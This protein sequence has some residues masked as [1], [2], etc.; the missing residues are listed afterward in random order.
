MSQRLF[1]LL[2]ALLSLSPLEAQYI[3]VLNIGYTDN[4]TVEYKANG[5]QL[6]QH[7][8]WANL[9]APLQLNEQKDYLIPMLDYTA[10][11]LELDAYENDQLKFHDVDLG[12]GY[13][14]NWPQSPW[15]GYIGV[16]LAQTSDFTYF[17]FRELNYT[18][19]LLA[20][21]ELKKTLSFRLGFNFRREAFGHLFVP[22]VG[23]NWRI[24][25]QLRLS[26]LSFDHLKLEY[27]FAR[28]LGG[29]IR[30]QNA[31]YSFYL[32]NTYGLQNGALHTF[33]DKFPYTP[34]RLTAYLDVYLTDHLVA[35]GRFGFEFAKNLFHEDL[36]DAENLLSAY[37]GAVEPGLVFEFGLAWR[38]PLID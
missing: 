12:L 18:F 15:R 34:Q 29:G 28:R 31:S 37:N 8:L 2:I 21:Y 22:L 5:Q 6:K 35:I 32:N 27:Q 33:G 13:L 10:V 26:Y 11:F 14:K 17:D 4:R 1:F 9:R 7:G 23:I 19:N 30:L 25:D 3:D 16:G 24:N 38:I 36:D 20:F